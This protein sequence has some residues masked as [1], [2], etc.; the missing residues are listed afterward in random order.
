MV[1]NVADLIEVAD[2]TGLIQV[3]HQVIASLLLI[4]FVKLQNLLKACG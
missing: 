4:G 1:R 3:C 2:F